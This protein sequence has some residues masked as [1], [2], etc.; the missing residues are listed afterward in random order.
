[1]LGRVC[2][3]RALSG[4]DLCVAVLQP[5][6]ARLHG[7]RG[8]RGRLVSGRGSVIHRLAPCVCVSVRQ[9]DQEL[10]DQHQ[11]FSSCQQD[12]QGLAESPRREPPV[13]S[14]VTRGMRGC[15]AHEQEQGRH[16]GC[17]RSACGLLQRAQS[18]DGLMHAVC[19][20]AALEERRWQTILLLAGKAGG[21]RPR[22]RV[23]V[24]CCSC[25]AACH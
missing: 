14:R 19:V 24:A 4:R 16:G 5:R 15:R 10:A 23:A 9:G 8:E 3:C 6:K 25:P 1:M 11:Q 18:M 17:A 21:H 12:G 22:G 7:C 20:A 2:D 13:G